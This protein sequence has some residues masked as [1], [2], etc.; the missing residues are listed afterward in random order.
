MTPATLFAISPLVASDRRLRLVVN[1]RDG[2]TTKG[3]NLNRMWAALGEDER[4]EGMRFAAI[5]LHDAEDLVHPGEI[6]LY[7]RHLGENAMVQIP[8][9]PIIAR[10]ARWIGGHY[11]DEFAEAHGKELV[12]RSRLSMPLPSAGVGCALTRH[13]LALLAIDRGG[14][15]F[16]YNS[17]TE[18]Y[19][20]GM[21][22]GAYGLK[23]RFVDAPGPMG[24]RIVSR[25]AFPDRADAAVRQKARW[26][27]GIALAGWDHLGW[28]GSRRHTMAGS[29][30]HIWLARWMLWRD[31]RAPLAALVLLAAYT[32]LMLTAFG[33]AGQAVLGWK[34]ETLGDGT[35]MLLALNAM[36]LV[37]RLGMRSLFAGRC[38]GWREAAWAVPRAFVA[39]IMAMLAA[40][41]AVMIYWRMLRS[42]EVVWDKTEHRE[43]DMAV[44]VATAPMVAR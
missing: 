34:A 42:G 12:V 4:A 2:P 17:L 5:V 44:E 40:R 20:L 6:A 1:E 24:D 9:V 19:E 13:T 16:R 32:G 7:R 21:V 38:Y 10:G 27:A 11:G 8:V 35:R 29:P 39:N 18:D 26:I 28:P 3:D 41:R 23:A 15:P 31:R 33:W 14:D 43:S 37:W 22:I 36:M 25:G 30:G